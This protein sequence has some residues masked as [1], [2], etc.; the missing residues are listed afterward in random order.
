M[1]RFEDRVALVVQVGSELARA[2]AVRLAEEGARVVV[3]DPLEASVERAVRAVE[4]VGGAATG[5]V[6]PLGDEAA[7]HDLVRAVDDRHGRLDALVVA[8]GQVDW[9]EPAEEDMAR[10]EESLRINLLT[11]VFLTRSFRP[12]LARSGA[13]SVVIYGSVD[14]THGNPQ[15]PA[16][17]SA[18][19]ALVPFVHTE[20]HDVA[21]LGIRVN[22]VAGA[23]ILPQGPEAPLRPGPPIDMGSV[24][25]HT[26]L[27]RAATPEDVA[28]TVAFLASA[29]AAY[30][31]GSVVTLDGGRTAIT[32]GTGGVA[33]VPQPA[34]PGGAHR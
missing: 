30:V 11:P 22:L 8:V 27:G 26:P 20:A 2:C 15:F 21:P 19:G 7:I 28:A 9:W 12:L 33:S 24:A 3:V 23:A 29:D 17:S 18:R 32:P 13:G 16:Y 34:D 5:L 25:R 1:R 4:E 6:A 10:W 31:T 14:G